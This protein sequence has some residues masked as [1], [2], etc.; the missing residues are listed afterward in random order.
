[1]VFNSDPV[2]RSDL[3]G[4]STINRSLAVLTEGMAIFNTPFTL[5][6]RTP[7]CRCERERLIEQHL[8]LKTIRF[9]SPLPPLSMSHWGYADLRVKKGVSRDL[10]L[11]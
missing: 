11:S 7:V 4:A 1:M 10:P 3:F 2:Y 6:R 9:Y 8:I 5:N